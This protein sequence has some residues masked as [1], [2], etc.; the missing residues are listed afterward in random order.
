MQIQKNKSVMR[1]DTSS[2]VG[3]QSGPS[4]TVIDVG[5]VK[6]KFEPVPKES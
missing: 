4:F 6:V 3:S 5:K 2:S 1:V